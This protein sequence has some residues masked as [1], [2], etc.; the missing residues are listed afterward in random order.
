MTQEQRD[1]LHRELS[2]FKK[3]K[4]FKIRE[5]NLLQSES[6]LTPF[7][8]VKEYYEIYLKTKNILTASKEIG[9]HHTNLFLK[10]K[11]YNFEMF[12]HQKITD[13]HRD[14][15]IMLYS[16]WNNKYQ[17]KSKGEYYRDKKQLEKYLKE[18][19]SVDT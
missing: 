5:S 18:Q 10:F 11:K 8:K 15:L 19:G 4:V 17:V 12:T 1:L 7:E 2:D 3:R 9:I 6:N 16:D 14:T 13:K